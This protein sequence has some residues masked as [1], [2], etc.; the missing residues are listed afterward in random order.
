MAVELT[1]ADFKATIEGS[2]KPVLVDFWA[3]WCSPCIHQGTIIEKW[4]QGKEDKVVLA[5]VNV[6]QAGA[7]AASFGITAIP[8][9]ILFSGGK[10][11]ARA[12]GVQR[13][14][15]LDAMLEKA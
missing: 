12:V 8:T 13:E 5:K 4:I 9:L 7:T 15:D 2:E 14:S 11:V 3:T 10:E 6:D 1:D